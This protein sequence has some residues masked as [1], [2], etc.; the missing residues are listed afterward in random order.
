MREE[1]KALRRFPSFISIAIDPN[2]VGV[3][4]ITLF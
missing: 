4:F 1:V 2:Y 3:V